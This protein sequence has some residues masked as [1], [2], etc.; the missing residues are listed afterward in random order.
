MKLSELWSCYHSDKRIEGFSPY[1]LK[2]Y[3]IQS[4][5]LIRHLGDVDVEEIT[6]PH[7]KEYLAKDAERLKPSS[8][9][10][11]VR[12]LKSLFKYAHDE[13]FIQRNAS[14]KLKEPKQGNR[15]PKA[16]TEEDVETLREA[17]QSTLEHALIEFIFSTGCRL[18]EVVQLNR[19]AID[20]ENRSVIVRGKG[21]KER[22]VYFTVK[23]HIWMK[24][25]LKERKDTDIALF[26]TER[27]PHRMGK[28]QVRY[29]V[30]RVAKRAGIEGTV[31]PHKLR[32]TYAT[33]LLN[34]G[35]PLEVIQS[36]LGHTKMETT[37]LYTHLSGQ[38]RQELY[39]KYF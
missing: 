39:R 14:S 31:Y 12:Y 23:C 29:I 5:L 15:I 36:F 9:G 26:V 3:G 27:D 30:K 10:H 24:K 13:G 32:H 17:C 6:L 11:R 8:L 28:A 7:L 16:M 37:R 20:W 21:D 38:K 1:T 35:A 19:N 25:Y 2:G 18:G 33:H 4:N 22:E 34:N